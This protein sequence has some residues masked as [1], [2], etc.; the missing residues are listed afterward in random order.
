MG[1]TAIY[2]CQEGITLNLGHANEGY[3]ATEMVL[4]ENGKNIE[5]HS[6]S[7]SR[8]HNNFLS[9]TWASALVRED[10][11]ECYTS[12]R[13]GLNSRCGNSDGI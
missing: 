4:A 12:E 5:L 2:H 7:S 6:A 10:C 13:L 8:I 11:A 1:Y 9:N 3:D